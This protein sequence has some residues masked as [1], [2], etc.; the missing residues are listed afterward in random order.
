MVS[1]IHIHVHVVCVMYYIKYIYIH[2]PPVFLSCT[3]RVLIG[4]FSELF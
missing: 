1:Y 4:V 3:T 2:V